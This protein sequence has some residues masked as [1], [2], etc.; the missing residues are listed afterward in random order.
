MKGLPVELTTELVKEYHAISH[1]FELS[2]STVQ[3]FTDADI[4]IYWGGQWWY[5]KGVNF[6]S[7]TFSASPKVDSIQFEMD[8]VDLGVSTVIMTEEV[9]GKSCVIY[10]VALNKNMAVLGSTKL[11]VGFI[12]QIEIDG[13]KGRFTI[14]NH[15]IRW[16]MSTPRRIHQATCMWTFKGTQCGYAGAD[17]WCDHS[18]ERCNAVTPNNKLNFGGFRWLPA[19]AEKSIWWGKVPR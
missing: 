6:D 10:Q 11:F 1:L 9:R 14:Y 19:L 3:R 8:N 7:A 15:F 12:D 13:K 17:T 2:F 16:K 18:W 4:D 5:D